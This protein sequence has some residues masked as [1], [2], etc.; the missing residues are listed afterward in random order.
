[1]KGSAGQR[2]LEEV[3]HEG[4]DV[5]VAGAGPAGSMAALH[6]ARKGRRVLLA[7]RAAFP[8]EKVCG[9]AL[10]PDAVACLRRAGLWE[11]VR[12]AG[13]A[14][15]AATVFSP[16]RYELDVP[17]E[18][19]TLKRQVLDDLLAGAAAE[20]GA[21]F[22]RAAVRAAEAVAGGVAVRFEGDA[23]DFRS[24]A[25]I[26]ATGAGVSL[27]RGLG[28]VEA[29]A[30]TAFAMRCY[31]KSEMDLDRLVVAYDRST[32]PGYA[33]IFPMGE[34]E[35]NVGCGVLAREGKPSVNL[36]EAYEKFMRSFPLA[37]ELSEKARASTPLKGAMLRCGL[38]G[39]R[40]L[41]PGPV[42]AVGEAIGTTFPYTGEGIGKAMETGEMAAS[43]LAEALEAGHAGRLASLPD[44]LE[45]RLRKRYRGYEV[46][47]RWFARPWLNDYLVKRG[48]TSAFVKRTLPEIFAERADPKEVFSLRGLI[49]IVLGF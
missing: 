10:I 26:L 11:E 19:L 5:L 25:L 41:A 2:P 38:R 28:M 46:A 17:G 43:F 14:P 49:K 39:T 31:V 23:R 20:A 8:R 18:Y 35:C 12:D 9:D 15:A 34:G 45:A 6:L 40:V 27:A 24:R 37:R 7:D 1:V 16:S 36:K 21:V 42:I 22:C 4:W 47:E 3:G 44:E 29:P 48:R 32:L 13:Y 30:P 33:W